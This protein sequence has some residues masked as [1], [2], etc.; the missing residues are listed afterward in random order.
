VAW[1]SGIVSVS[2]V[3]VREI[4]SR[5]GGSVL[6]QIMLYYICMYVE[7]A[8]LKKAEIVLHMLAIFFVVKNSFVDRHLFMK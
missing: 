8:C 5:Q 3:L 6:K 2:G 1:S 4:E 7:K